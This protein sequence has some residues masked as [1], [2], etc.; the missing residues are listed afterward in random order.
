MTGLL[1]V[2]SDFT[3][4]AS[5][6]LRWICSASESVLHSVSEGGIPLEKSSGFDTSMSTFPRRLL[7]PAC[8]SASRDADPA[9][10]LKTTSPCFAAS[11]K[12]PAEALAPLAF[13]QAIAFGFCAVREPIF[14]SCPSD[15]SFVPSLF[16]TSPVPRTPMRMRS[17]RTVICIKGCRGL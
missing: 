15:A 4:L 1:V 6:K 3:T 12:V 10:Q 8:F 11:A 9:V 14:T 7:A 5:G 2:L 16:P 17:G 13:A